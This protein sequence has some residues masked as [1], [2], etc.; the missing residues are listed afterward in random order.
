[1]LI[2]APRAFLRTK[3]DLPNAGHFWP[4]DEPMAAAEAIIRAYAT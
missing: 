2:F 1:M 3:L 4:E